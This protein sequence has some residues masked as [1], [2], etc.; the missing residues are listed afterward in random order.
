MNEIVII[1]GKVV[2][3]LGLFLLAVS[4]ITEGFKL[5]AGDSL[6]ELLGRWTKT[7]ANGVLSGITITGLVQSSSAVTVATIGF[8]NAGLLSMPN[9]LGVVYGANIGTTVTGWLVAAIGF[10]IKI[11]ILALPLIGIG[12]LLRLNGAHKKRGAIGWALVGFGL[13]FVGVDVLKEA[14]EGIAASARIEQFESDN[15]FDLLIFIGIGFLMTVLTQASAAAIAII[16][17]AATGGIITLP[18]AAA[19]IIGANIGTTSTAL[20]AVIGATPNA[21]RVAA[22]HIFF[23]IVTATVALLLLPLMLWLVQVS[24]KL[25]GMEDIPAVTLALF[26]T[27]FNIL[28]LLVMWPI[29]GYL[30]TFLEG[31]FRTA[32]EMEGKPIYLD[33]NVLVSP[34]LAFN[35]VCL[36]LVHV[37]EIVRRM[38]KG[39][40]STELVISEK[41]ASDH[42]AA[43]KL[44]LEIEAFI[45]QLGRDNLPAEVALE[46][47]KVLRS[48]QY[49]SAA[50]E[51]ASFIAS[52]QSR[53]KPIQ[54]EALM[55]ALAKF[56]AELV[57][58]IDACDV[59]GKKFS[60]AD[61]D[62]RF[63]SFDAHYHELKERTL[64]AG[65]HQRIKIRD[66]SF[67][68]E[69]L[70]RMHR[71]AEQMAKA[72]RVMT[73][74][75][76]VS[77]LESHGERLPMAPEPELTDS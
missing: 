23:N 11:D 54:D 42:A 35:A 69:Q 16:L 10:K 66:M 7:T 45:S 39:S 52:N 51:L 47:T 18:A 29:T 8:V 76:A 19:M 41:L 4:M 46:L 6:S 44:V 75:L 31:R 15:W 53:I 34:S 1:V 68:I 70:S 9:A 59:K 71:M 26:H 37:A 24:S 13:F 55:T 72:T 64:T 60:L 33:K 32:E 63:T 36:E 25:L 57:A 48:S 22:A 20:F 67:T 2:G 5:A 50:T 73:H 61:S 56:R 38:G 27:A 40:L 65:A 74:L 49:L 62:N 3:G 21:K 28:G 12:M 30:A 58:L 43:Q 14:F 77:T 17:T